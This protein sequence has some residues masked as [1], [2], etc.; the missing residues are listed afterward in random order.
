MSAV[1]DEARVII[2]AMKKIQSGPHTD[3]L[4]RAFAE[5]WNVAADAELDKRIVQTHVENIKNQMFANIPL[6]GPDPDYDP[7][8][9]FKRCAVDRAE[10]TQRFADEL[11]AA[12]DVESQKPIRTWETL[13][14]VGIISDIGD[15]DR[16]V[17]RHEFINLLA[18]SQYSMSNR[19]PLA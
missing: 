16:E 7:N 12:L 3:I 4:E 9:E 2:E 10:R 17:D 11:A 1:V 13:L 5:L 14:E 15:H 8:D 6:R 18:G 19:S